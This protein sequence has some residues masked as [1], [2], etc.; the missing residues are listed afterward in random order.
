[1]ARSKKIRF[2]IVS[3]FK[4]IVYGRDNGK[5]KSEIEGLSG[6]QETLRGI[7]SPGSNWERCGLELISR[8]LEASCF[9]M[10]LG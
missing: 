7:Q 3:G 4:K 8:I 9:Q 10:N 1:M 5:K 6:I 2:G